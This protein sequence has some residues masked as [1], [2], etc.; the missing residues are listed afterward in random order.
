MTA[1]IVNTPV[2]MMLP[3]TSAVADGNPSDLAGSASGET[4]AGAGD[5][6][7][8]GRRLTLMTTCLLGAVT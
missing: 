8:T 5:A 3:M 2:P 1:G 7:T 6:C 4:A